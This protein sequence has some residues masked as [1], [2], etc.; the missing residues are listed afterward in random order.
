MSQKIHTVHVCR[1][2][3]WTVRIVHGA[4]ALVCRRVRWHLLTD[5]SAGAVGTESFWPQEVHGSFSSSNKDFRGKRAT[6][7]KSLVIMKRSPEAADEDIRVCYTAPRFS[8]LSKYWPVWPLLLLS[9]YLSLG[10]MNLHIPLCWSPDLLNGVLG[11]LWEVLVCLEDTFIC[12][13]LD[14]QKLWPFVSPCQVS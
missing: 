11:N 6:L 14:T 10:T 8:F 2:Q 1:G 5:P 12:L 4:W 3:T 9:Q 13:E 7:L